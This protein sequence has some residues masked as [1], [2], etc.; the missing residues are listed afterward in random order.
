MPNG[1]LNIISEEDFITADHETSRRWNYKLLSTIIEQNKALERNLNII[2]EDQNKCPGRNY[3][4][5]VDKV[6]V[7]VMGLIGGFLAVIVALKAKI[8][9]TIAQ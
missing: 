3:R 9:G 2:I 7:G 4:P 1:S 5:V 8:I 6:F